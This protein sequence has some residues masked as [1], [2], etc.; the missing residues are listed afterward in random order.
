MER[1]D[2][3]MNLYELKEAIR[4]LVEKETGNAVSTDRID[5]FM[6]DIGKMYLKAN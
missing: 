3:L 1:I 2:K 6:G 4:N 5:K